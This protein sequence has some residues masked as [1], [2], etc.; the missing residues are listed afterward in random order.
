MLSFIKLSSPATGEYWEALILFEDEHLL[1]LNKPAGL[2]TKPDRFAPDRPS[3]MQLLH[4]DIERGAPWAKERGL[5]YLM[6]AHRMDCETS[7]V[8]LFAKNRPA[9]INL[10]TQ[11]GS[12]KPNRIFVALV[13]GVAALEQSV[14][15]TDAKLAP[16]PLQMGVV[17][18]DPKE[19]KRARTEFTVRERFQG[20]MLMECHPLTDRRHQLRV[21][22]KH[23]GFR[24]VGDEFYGGA[25][26]LL[27]KLKEGY[28]LKPGH[29]E[30]PL[31][32]HVALHAEQLIF[33][34][35]VTGAEVKIEAPRPKDLTVAVKYLR[36]FAAAA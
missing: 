30:R 12:E 13:Q 3:L 7:G 26:L 6:H 32:S 18:V 11:F 14:F 29:T 21:H 16:H 5:T 2:L 8:L 36:R 4:H 20:Y 22:L 10:A 24:I 23:V 35:P 17:R 1:A 27:S 25:P 31:I 15:K 19:G 34:H 28:R 9:L 33:S